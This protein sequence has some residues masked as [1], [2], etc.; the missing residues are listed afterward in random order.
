[1]RPLLFLLFLTILLLCFTRKKDSAERFTPTE[2]E[3]QV[4]FHN[5]TYVGDLQDAAALGAWIRANLKKE[6]L[7]VQVG[8]NPA[9]NWVLSTPVWLSYQNFLK[10][11]EFTNCIV[12]YVINW[13]MFSSPF[14]D[15]EAADTRR[16][17]LDMPVFSGMPE[18]RYKIDSVKRLAPTVGNLPFIKNQNQEYADL[19]EVRMKLLK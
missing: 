2:T 11:N 13:R 12:P 19:F 7:L 10:K 1:M 6:Y 8:K 18:N 4:L 14:A 15:S 3:P 16:S 9:E 17:T 5:D